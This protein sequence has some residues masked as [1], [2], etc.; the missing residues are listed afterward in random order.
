MRVAI[1][2]SVHRELKLFFLRSLCHKLNIHVPPMKIVLHGA[3]TYGIKLSRAGC[4][5]ERTDPRTAG[6]LG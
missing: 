6:S 4:V 3:V 2:A 1:G 5:L